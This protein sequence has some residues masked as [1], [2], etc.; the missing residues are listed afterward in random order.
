MADTLNLEDAKRMYR[1]WHHAQGNRCATA[2]WE[3]LSDEQ[4]AEWL[5]K[6]RRSTSSVSEGPTLEVPIMTSLDVPS[7]VPKDSARAWA[8]GWNDCRAATKAAAPADAPNTVA[9]GGAESALK[10]AETRMDTGFEGGA[11][12]VDA[13]EEVPPLPQPMRKVYERPHG[14]QE[15]LYYTAAQMRDYALAARRASSV[16]AI[17]GTGGEKESTACRACNGSGWVTRD[18]DIGTDQECFVCDGKGIVP[19]LPLEAKAGKSQE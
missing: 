5:E 4:R 8:R 18:A 16:P 6:A 3:G 9:Q 14:T 15:L 13:R 10:S 19:S 2:P 7:D 1:S 11:G 12:L 17:P